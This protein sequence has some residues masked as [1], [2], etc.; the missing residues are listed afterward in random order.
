MSAHAHPDRYLPLS[1]VKKTTATS[2]RNAEPEEPDCRRIVRREKERVWRDAMPLVLSR[3]LEYRQEQAGD[4]ALSWSVGGK[5]QR[6][7]NPKGT[8]TAN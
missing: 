2:Q 1:W 5:V 4:V 6:Q 3:E 7:G 8:S